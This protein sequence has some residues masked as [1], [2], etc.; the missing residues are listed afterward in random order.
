MVPRGESTRAL[1]P[2]YLEYWEGRYSNTIAQALS[3]ASASS[4]CER[5]LL[6]DQ[7]A[8]SW[9]STR[10]NAVDSSSRTL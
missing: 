2:Y 8:E 6:E 3:D 7:E 10:Q 5:L 4:Q 9:D 1:M